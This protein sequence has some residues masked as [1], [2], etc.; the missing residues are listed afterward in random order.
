MNELIFACNGNINSS[1]GWVSRTAN[2]ESD[3]YDDDK[4]NRDHDQI[5]DEKVVVELFLGVANGFL[6]A[7][8]LNWIHRF[9]AK[10]E[11]F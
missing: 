10:L 6:R 7:S 8:G 3:S 1:I 5:R 2:E 9:A 4:L 11:S